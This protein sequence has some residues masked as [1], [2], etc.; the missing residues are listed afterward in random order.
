MSLL[1]PR[2]VSPSPFLPLSLSPCPRPLFAG[3][4][5]LCPLLLPTPQPALQS[6]VSLLEDLPGLL[7]AHMPVFSARASLVT[8]SSTISSVSGSRMNTTT[9]LSFSSHHSLTGVSKTFLTCPP[10]RSPTLASL[11][12]SRMPSHSLFLSNHHASYPTHF[13]YLTLPFPLSIFR[14]PPSIFPAGSP[15]PQSS[16]TR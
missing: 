11:S 3:R 14:L 10:L 1:P 7:P 5:S 4:S 12:S 6:G 2:F 16:S 9:I 15:Y 13:R 8:A